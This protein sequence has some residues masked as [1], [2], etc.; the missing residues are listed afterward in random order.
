MEEDNKISIDPHSLVKY[1]SSFEPH[2]N[3]ELYSNHRPKMD[4]NQKQPSLDYYRSMTQTQRHLLIKSLYVNENDKNIFNVLAYVH[5]EIQVQKID[6]QDVKFTFNDE[7]VRSKFSV[8]YTSFRIAHPDL[9]G[10]LD[11][12]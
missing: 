9:C 12:S 7:D 3:K 1:S 6:L 11:R 5:A 4:F 8:V 2:T 10:H